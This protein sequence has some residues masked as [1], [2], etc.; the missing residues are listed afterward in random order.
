MKHGK[1]LAALAV[2]AA[3]FLGIWM[4]FKPEGVEGSKNL[5]IQVVFEDESSKDFQI[6]TDA[7]FLGGA[8][9]EA[10]LIEG[11]EGPYGLFITV[12]DGVTADSGLQQWWCITKGGE[13]V[14]TAAGST[15]IADGDH[16]EITLKTGY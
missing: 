16:F 7:E 12:V 5:D 3:V 9:T 6:F 8:L 2:A 4:Y 14:N 10:G 1:L 13:R 11:E 15:P